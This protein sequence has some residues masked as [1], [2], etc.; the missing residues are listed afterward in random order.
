MDCEG[1][2]LIRE[3][4]TR[5]FGVETRT[6]PSPPF[7]VIFAFPAF[8]SPSMNHRV[9]LL[10]CLILLVG[11]IAGESEGDIAYTIFD[12]KASR[13]PPHRP[14]QRPMRYAPEPII[15]KVIEDIPIVLKPPSI[16]SERSQKSRKPK[17]QKIT[18]DTDILHN[19]SLL[20]YSVFKSTLDWDCIQD[21]EL[22]TLVHTEGTRTIMFMYYHNNQTQLIARRYAYCKDWIF[23]VMLFKSP[24]M[25]SQ[26]YRDLFRPV[27]LTKWSKEADFII[28]CTY[29]HAL[30]EKEIKAGAVN[31]LTPT[32][33]KYLI[34]TAVAN[35]TD[36]LPLEM[37]PLAFLTKS[38][39][40]SHGLDAI[41]AW[42]I[43]LLKMGYTVDD[44]DSCNQIYAFWRSAYLVRPR[45]L[46][47]LTQNM[48]AAMDLV[49]NNKKINTA[50]KRNAKYTKGD[51]VV[52]MQVFGTAYYQM[53][54][55]VFER[56]PAFFLVMMNANVPVL[57]GEDYKK[58]KRKRKHQAALAM[59]KE[60]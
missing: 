49:D 27:N 12:H 19:P 31:L 23:P 53:H 7:L 24:Y 29:K 3:L 2:T 57:L 43:L 17:I 33:V 58:Q 47:A 56:L 18:N 11:W 30:D 45:V 48:T 44:L 46:Q 41:K 34:H 22:E 6:F 21:Q 14:K 39:F 26:V 51:P 15:G 60:A 59:V 42:N 16:P 38:L 4:Q 35:A 36:L 1:A 8:S 20:Q 54:P 25:E 9:Y 50:F 52:A 32:H 5:N 13:P 28:T 10:L 55:F 37:R 40:N